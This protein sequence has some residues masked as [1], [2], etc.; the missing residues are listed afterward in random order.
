M[1]D[2]I[3]FLSHSYRAAEVNLRVFDL[4]SESLS[5]Q[6]EVDEGT[7][8]TS[9]T[10]LER[11]V[12]AA[13]AFVGVY[14][15]LGDPLR[16]PSPEELQKITRYFRLE[17]DMA[18]R[19]RKPYLVIMDRRLRGVLPVPDATYSHQ[20][21]VQEL[22]SGKE[23]FRLNE[24]RRV[25][26]AFE[27]DARMTSPSEWRQ[28][29]V[30]L[31]MPPGE[32]RAAVAEALKPVHQVSQLDW[33][34][35]LDLE[36]AIALR[37]CEWVVVDTTAPESAA[38]VAYL[39]GQA[40]PF[41]RLR[42]GEAEHEADKALFGTF[43]R[44]YA[45]NLLRWSD[46]DNLVE[47]LETVTELIENQ[48]RLISSQEDARDYFR[49][50]SGRKEAVFLSYAAEDSDYAKQIGDALRQRFQ[51]VFD[52]RVAG[53]I[54]LGADWLPALLENLSQSAVGVPLLSA[55]YVGSNYCL[56][57]AQRMADL[58]L[59]RKIRVFPIRL[60]GTRVPELEMI[61]YWHASRVTPAQIV[62]A[63]IAGL[64]GQ[65]GG[66]ASGTPSGGGPA[67]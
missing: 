2:L 63:I 15:V 39:R 58:H 54:P 26:R 28:G 55:S 34:V 38:L 22:L 13:D 18:V 57:E 10:R 53:N 24:L 20:Y 45:K 52:Y 21:E 6:F 46:V 49:R 5:L 65:P 66:A 32:A 47:Q 14:P 67:R 8:S 30:G 31:V 42:Q 36:T 25:V 11:M 29:T 33:P 56:D 61:Q 16:K 60:D 1:P 40:I 50:A 9:T 64:D 41:V 19:A 4:L 35:T 44:H 3:V 43:Q 17:L 7:T 12:R 51:R 48:P 37:Q 62:D 23:T 27:R 59:R